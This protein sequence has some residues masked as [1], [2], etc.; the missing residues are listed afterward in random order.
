[1]LV[2]S[3]STAICSPAMHIDKKNCR[4]SHEPAHHC[5]SISNT[6]PSSSPFV[7]AVVRDSAVWPAM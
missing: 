4:K 6:V 7:E 2:M 3:V 1:V 5:Q